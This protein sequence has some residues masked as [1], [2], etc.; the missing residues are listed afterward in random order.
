MG[1]GWNGEQVDIDHSTAQRFINA[2]S[3]FGNLATSPTLKVG[4]IFEMLS[5]PESVDQ[6]EFIAEPHTVPSI[7][8]TKQVEDM[9]FKIINKKSPT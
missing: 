3:Q 9:T 7:G 4:K 8:E 6:A 1:S 5:L 2:F